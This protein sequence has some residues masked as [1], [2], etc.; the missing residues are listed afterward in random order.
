MSTKFLLILTLAC[1]TG[2]RASAQVNLLPQGSFEDPGAKTEWA[3][4]FNIPNNQEF[5]VH[6]FNSPNWS[7]PAERTYPPAA[8][9][10]SA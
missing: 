3:E 1:V 7:F 6:S 2:G 9:P 10:T 8:T 5:R 4:G